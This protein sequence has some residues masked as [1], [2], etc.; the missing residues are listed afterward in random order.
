[1]TSSIFVTPVF[2]IIGSTIFSDGTGVGVS[3][4]ICSIE[5]SFTISSF[6]ITD[7]F[8]TKVVSTIFVELLSGITT[9]SASVGTS[10]TL[11]GA[12]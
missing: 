4:S 2:S 7:A 9:T 3:V 10:G 12:D 5:S 1:M 8:S 11:S 6:S